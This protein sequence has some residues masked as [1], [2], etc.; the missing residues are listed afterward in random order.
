MIKKCICILL[1]LLLL[2]PL[3]CGQKNS[4]PSMQDAS[5]T[6]LFRESADTATEDAGILTAENT[7]TPPE[8]TLPATTAPVTTVPPTTVP[9]TTA[10]VTTAPPA[11]RA[12]ATTVPATTVPATTRAP[13][14]TVPAT[15]APP[16]TTQPGPVCTVTVRCDTILQNKDKLK[17]GKA[18]FV[19]ADGVILDKTAV[20]FTDGETAFDVLKRACE[21]HACK[22][23]CAYCLN[24]GV[25]LEYTYTPGFATYYVEGIHQIYEKD[26]GASSGWMYSVNGTFPNVGVSSYTVR[27]GDTIVFA[28]TC[29]MGEDIGNFY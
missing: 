29:D 24:G 18:P 22:E 20:S 1:P 8:A 11:T 5:Y 13:V 26:C 14:T 21:T 16:A 7:P 6:Y 15:T 23:R 10:P 25:Q 27:A 2:L 3:G 28:Y 4:V 19:P 17:A 9:P 12:P